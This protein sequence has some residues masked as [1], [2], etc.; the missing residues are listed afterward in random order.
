VSAVQRAAPPAYRL[1]RVV[2]GED[3]I[4]FTV[5]RTLDTL[6]LPPA[7]YACYPAGNI[8]L[9]GQWADKLQRMGLKQAWP[10]LLIVYNGIFGI[11]LKR[12]GGR[13]SKTRLVR[14]KNGSLK[15]LTGQTEMFPRLLVAGFR[16]IAVCTTPGQVLAT[17]TAWDVPLR[18]YT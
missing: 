18:G 1:T 14:R 11:E 8:P 3:D 10:D 12:V 17:L 6:L 13:L 5:A 7:E 9:P 15:Q 16:D 2:V 4:H